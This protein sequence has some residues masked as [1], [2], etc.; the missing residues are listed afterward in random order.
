MEGMAIVVTIG[1]KISD[2]SAS[3]DILDLELLI[4]TVVKIKNEKIKKIRA[5]LIFARVSSLPRHLQASHGFSVYLLSLM[6][7]RN[8]LLVVLELF[9]VFGSPPNFLFI[10]AALAFE[11]P[12]P[13]ALVL[14]GPTS[15]HS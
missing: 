12:C 14:R 15:S 4:F 13:S 11:A 7:F 6:Y 1:S 10:P 2:L 3:K 9:S 8:F 5:P